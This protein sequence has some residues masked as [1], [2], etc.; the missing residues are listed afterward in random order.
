MYPGVNKRGISS[1][2]ANSGRIVKLLWVLIILL[3]AGQACAL[4]S[5]GPQEDAQVIPTAVPTIVIALE[6]TKTAVPTPVAPLPPALVEV[7]PLS[8]T[9]LAPGIAPVFYFNQPMDRASVEASLEIQPPLAARYEWLDDSTLRLIPD[10][11]VNAEVSL[12]LTINARARAVNGLAMLQPIQVDYRAVESLRVVERLPQPGGEDINPSSA[13][14]VTFNRPIV[15]LAAEPAGL[16]PAF[17]IEP[18]PGL[19]PV[20]GRG[21]WLNTSTYIFYPEPVLYGGTQY[22]VRMNPDLTAFDGSP[23]PADQVDQEWSFRT[24]SPAILSLKP[25]TEQPVQLDDVFVLEFN[26]PMEKASVET[27]FSLTRADGSAVTGSFVWNAAA[28]EVT[29]KPTNLLERDTGLGLVLFGSAR[30]QGGAPL[31]QDF[32]ASLVTFPQFSVTQTRP[33]AGDALDSSFGFSTVALSFSAPIAAGQDLNRL[34]QINPPINGQSASRSFDGNEIYLNGY[35]Q[36]STSY[37]LE[38]ARDL[39]DRWGSVL[40][41]PYTF[42][43]STV[44]ARPSITLPG[45]QSK[46]RAVFVPYGETSLAVTSTNIERLALSRGTLSLSDFI[47]AEKD[48]QGLQGW[49]PL[50]KASWVQLLYPN[51]NTRER[52]DI[53]LHE[54]DELLEPGLYFLK[55]DVQPALEDGIDVSPSLL[56]V[57]PIQLTFKTSLHQAF[58]WAV[59]IAN[60]EPLAGASVTIYDQTARSVAV[61]VTDSNGI[62]QAELPLSD[63]LDTSYYAVIGQPGDPDFSLAAIGWAQ[64]VSPWELSMPYQKESPDPQVYLYTDR[65]IYRPGQAVNLR[66][67]VRNQDNG[68]FSLANLGELTVDVVGAYDPV[69]SQNQVLTSLRLSLDDFG[70]ASGVYTLPEDAVPGEYTLRVQELQYQEIYFKVAEYRKPEI[71][72]QVKFDHPDRLYGQDVLAQVNARYFFGAPAGNAV[73]HWTLFG[74]PGYPDLPNG[75]LTGKADTSWMEDRSIMGGMADF[76]ISE[77]QETTAPDGSLSIQVPGDLIRERLSTQSG[78]LFRLTLEV[79]VEDESGLPVSSRDRMNLHWRPP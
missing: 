42:T 37:T 19:P 54:A 27:D 25:G 34:I 4:P 12:N 59:K 47:L 24:A 30:S 22:V 3:I 16:T 15:P 9:E 8:H 49:E 40:G 10:Q 55:V 77:G 35:F 23:L 67:V 71:D 56:V 21:E 33:A 52:V 39:S 75:L 62:C 13:V 57:S 68:R 63:A 46:G 14:V 79:T 2:F 73:V 7:V 32:A 78:R 69:T 26:Q 43:F 29:F 41:L 48:Y 17:T 50:V 31:G 53:P 61:C 72:L 70:A 1:V 44:V 74:T 58:V 66:A 6:E 76:Y 11:P 38:I 65:P 18:S 45:S 64:G 5:Q 36:P 20:N 28:T 51:L 60:Q